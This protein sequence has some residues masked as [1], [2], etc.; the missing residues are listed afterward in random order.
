M[1]EQR[2]ERILS[3]LAHR[4]AISVVDVARLLRVSEATVRRDLDLLAKRGRVRRTHGGAVLSDHHEELSLSLKATSSL[5]EKRQI[6]ASVAALVQP[7]QVIGCTGGTTVAH[8]ARALRGK[9]VVVLTNAINVAAE[10]T[11]SEETEVIVSGG[12]LRG[13]SFELVG[14]VAERTF[15][16]MYVDVAIMGVDGI[17]LERGLT[18]FHITEAHANRVLIE[19]A[20]EVW[21]VADHSK[22]EKV[23]PARI[24]P[25]SSISRLFTTVGASATFLNEL[26]DQGIDVVCV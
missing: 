22:L 21:V 2:H 3:E 4:G 12:I 24:G 11:S 13:R 14:H 9:D 26:R 19:Q 23:T 17:S 18:T 7:G 1:K 5:A 25:L 15:R 16:E 10:L 20:R 8:V 6:G